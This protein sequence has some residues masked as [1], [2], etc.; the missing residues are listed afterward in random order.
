MESAVQII[1][2]LISAMICMLMRDFRI[3][4]Y[5]FGFGALFIVL[6]S[7]LTKREREKHLEELTRYLMRLQDQLALPEIKKYGEG[8]LGILENEIYKLVVLVNEQSSGAVREKEYLAK[9]LSDISHQ[10][11]T[12]LS[13]IT[14]MIDLIMN[15]DLSETDRIAFVE[16]ID[17]Q[18][19]QI[20]WLVRNL[21]T[22]SQLDANMLK[23][24]K[25]R[26]SVNQLLKKACQPLEISAELKEIALTI[27][28]REEIEVICDEKWT[29]EALSNLI[30]NCVEH[31]ASGGHVA[32]SVSQNNF[33]TN[34]EIAD[35]GKGISKEHLPHIFERF[36]K[37]DNQSSDS[38]GIGLAMSKQI[39]MMQNGVINV[40]SEEGV[41]TVFHIK[42]Y[43]E[44]V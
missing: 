16:K 12:P 26:V 8:Q 23:L 43:S 5:T 20:T 22:L 44:V 17:L 41:G 39:I 18:I 40:E 31:T 42:M 3:A 35:N 36:Y 32:I 38:V 19:N 11:K 33:A 2:I 6:I 28:C 7:I 24:K 21:L 27:N 13:S 1:I 37:A 15:P 10:I 14:I 30:K 25:E 29:A 34:I 4:A 9:M